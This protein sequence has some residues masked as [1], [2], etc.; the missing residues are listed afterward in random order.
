MEAVSDIAAPSAPV[1][2]TPAELV[3]LA[4]LDN[5]L[6][7]RAFFPKTYR[8]KSPSFQKDIWSDFDDPTKRMLNVLA[9]RG[10]AKTTTART[11]VSK[12]VAYGISRTILYIG[13][14]ESAALRSIRWMKTQV[15]KNT[16]WAQTFGIERGSKWTDEEIEI[17]HSKLDHPIWIIGVGITST[18]I[19]GINFDDYRPDLIVLDDT[20]QDENSATLEQREKINDLVHGAIK[21]SLT[22]ATEE[23]NA[24][25]VALNTPQHRDD[26]SQQA[27]DSPQWSTREI[28]CWTE[29]TRNLPVLQ[30]ESI[31]PDRYPTEILRA[32]KLEALRKNKLS[33]FAREMEVRLVMPEAAAFRP[34][35]L[36]INV[37]KPAHPFCV[38]GI[39]PVPPPSDRQLAKG[40]V[41]K[42]YEAHY[43][44]GR[45]G[46]EYFLME[47]MRNKGHE[48]NWTINTFF[49][50]AYKYRIARAIVESIAYQRVL[51]WLLEQEMKRRGLYY[52]IIPFVD[53]RRKQTRIIS[54][55][56][57]VAANGLIN[58]G[59]EDTIFAQQFCSFSE[60]YVDE[61]DDLDASAMALSDLIAPSLERGGQLRDQDVEDFPMLRRAP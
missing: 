29:A 42:D 35:W 57:G 46:G 60:T 38:L 54:T 40:L 43:V 59:P 24:K 34:E 5:D 44:W 55:F 61:D 8:Q 53:K 37:M 17:K 28:S 11:F 19:R 3:K 16:L 48:P 33:L 12:R 25:I 50:L 51:K 30:Q 13:A 10:A 52:S 45:E 22:P 1:E 26:Y 6:Y 4:A 27:K 39:D 58:I 36:K 41:G 9:F 7:C 23:P 20:L 47:G 32:E 21:N 56:S 14:N 49:H 15:D 18:G 2:I 31:W